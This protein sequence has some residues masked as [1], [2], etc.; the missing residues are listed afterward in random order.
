MPDSPLRAKSVDSTLKEDEC[1]TS[2]RVSGL[3]S[4]SVPYNSAISDSSTAARRS[5]DMSFDY[6]S[7]QPLGSESV[8]PTILPLSS[9]GQLDTNGTESDQPSLEG[10]LAMIES[11]VY[12]HCVADSSPVGSSNSPPDADRGIQGLVG[13]EEGGQVEE[14]VDPKE[15]VQDLQE[16]GVAGEEP[17][18]PSAFAAGILV[19]QQESNDK[20]HSPESAINTTSQRMVDDAAVPDISLVIGNHAS[21]MGSTSASTDTIMPTSAPPDPI[22][23][24]VLQLRE[25]SEG[26]NIIKVSSPGH[27]HDESDSAKEE[28]DPEAKSP[29]T[30]MQVEKLDAEVFKES[31]CSG[32]SLFS[33][34]LTSSV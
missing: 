25:W 23:T 21:V 32:E 18:S 15:E 12:P 17:V 2:S 28:D 22:A 34:M 4:T 29:D 5:L 33:S 14:A 20:Q 8:I 11:A 27:G 3:R 30:Q 16:T 10:I 31:S 24:D 1:S 13:A 7:K 9:S 6:H 19:A 26:Q